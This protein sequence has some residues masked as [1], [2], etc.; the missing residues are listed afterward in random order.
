MGVF[1]VSDYGMRTNV[2]KSEKKELVEA[3]EFRTEMYY[4]FCGAFIV[5]LK[6]SI[7]NYFPLLDVSGTFAV[8]ETILVASISLVLFALLSSRKHAVY[9]I[10]PIATII[11]YSL[12]IISSYSLKDIPAPAWLVGGLSIGLF[13]KSST[14]STK[15]DGNGMED[16]SSTNG[17]R[18]RRAWSYP[19]PFPNGWY[20]ITGTDDIKAGEVMQVQC[21]GR[22]FAV[23]R[24]ES[25]VV[26]VVDAFCPHLGANMALGGT[27]RVELYTR[28]SEKNFNVA[29]MSGASIAPGNVSGYLTKRHTH[30]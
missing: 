14:E 7:Q 23:F 29:F 9:T 5:A 13:L 3:R 11:F 16:L 28:L 19:A 26:S 6:I 18:R 2:K 15:L 8:S 12:P 21:V 10:P 25:G 17:D 24:G 4:V 1:L 30:T 20:R 22:Q 27:V